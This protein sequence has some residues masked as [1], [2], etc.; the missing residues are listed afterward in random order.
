LYEKFK[1]IFNNGVVDDT[2]I[3]YLVIDSMIIG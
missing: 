1:V 3:F 2:E